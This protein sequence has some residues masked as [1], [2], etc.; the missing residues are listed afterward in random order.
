MLKQL[1]K[2]TLQ[3]PEQPLFHLIGEGVLVDKPLVLAYQVLAFDLL[4]GEG[5]GIAPFEPLAF[6]AIFNNGLA[7]SKLHQKMGGRLYG[8]AQEVT[9]YTPVESLEILA[10]NFLIEASQP[11]EEGSVIQAEGHHRI[12]GILTS[13]GSL[14]REM[15]IGRAHV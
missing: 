9:A 5:F 3:Q 11:L 13:G 6:T 1:E 4:D 2:I 8:M 10:V 7:V 12:E 15:E 14:G